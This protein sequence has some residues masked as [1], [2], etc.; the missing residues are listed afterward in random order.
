[1]TTFVW[2]LHREACELLGIVR[3]QPSLEVCVDGDTVW[4]RCKDASD[5]LQRAFMQLPVVHSV[6]TDD[7][8]LIERGMR[9]PR[10][11]VAGGPWMPIAEWMRVTLPVAGL[12][13]LA[14]KAIPLE[15]VR[16]EEFKASQLLQTDIQAWAKYAASAPRV[17][18][19]HLSFAV[20]EDST[21]FVRGKPLP[22]ISGRRLVVQGRVAV[23]AGW[24]WRPALAVEVL[25]ATLAIEPGNFAVLVGDGGWTLLSEEV[26]VQAT[27]SAVRSA[28]EELGYVC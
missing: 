24:T 28:S 19:D 4:I 11:Y 20:A 16:S 17:R 1:M 23:E 26:F 2:K 5:D 18:L 14:P 12:S 3:T 27:R 13:G 25:E 10:G 22:P 9:V 6:A 8:Q 7:G 21:V 15:M